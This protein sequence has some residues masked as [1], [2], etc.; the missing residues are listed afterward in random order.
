MILLEEFVPRAVLRIFWFY[1]VFEPSLSLLPPTNCTREFMQFILAEE[2]HIA[3]GALRP[4]SSKFSLLACFDLDFPQYL[5][6]RVCEISFCY[7]EFIVRAQLCSVIFSLSRAF[8]FFPPNL[9]VIL[10]CLWRIL[11]CCTLKIPV[12]RFVSLNSCACVYAIP[13]C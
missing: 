2:F 5:C 7:L 1:V 13:C 12:L 9:Y 3:C 6:T 4:T 8:I 10:Y 11:T